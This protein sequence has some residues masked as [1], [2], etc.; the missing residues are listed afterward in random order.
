MTNIIL[1][2]IEHAPEKSHLLYW[3]VG[4][5]LLAFVFLIFAK[6]IQILDDVFD[7]EVDRFRERRRHHKKRE[8][9]S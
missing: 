9:K 4:A 7:N 8:E 1:H 5:L 3:L 6:A 2:H